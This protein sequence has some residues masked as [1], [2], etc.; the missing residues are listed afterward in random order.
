[1]TL[2]PYLPNSKK[3]SNEKKDKYW[4]CLKKLELGK[5]GSNEDD[6]DVMNERRAKINHKCIP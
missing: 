5:L 4:S 1:M 6:D 3:V 2:L